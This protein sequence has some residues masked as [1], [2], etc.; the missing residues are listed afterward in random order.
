MQGLV[1]GESKEMDYPRIER[2]PGW[3]DGKSQVVGQGEE[4]GAGDRW[5]C[6]RRRRMLPSHEEHWG[7]HREE[8]GYSSGLVPVPCRQEIRSFTS[9][10][11][12]FRLRC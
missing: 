6:S 9:V 3:L 10:W 1:A 12:R 5:L 11:E 4:K 7:S 2:K 8:S